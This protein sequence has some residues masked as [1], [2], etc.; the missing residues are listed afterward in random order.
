MSVSSVAKLE[1]AVADWDDWLCHEKRAAR[2]TLAS[3]RRDLNAFLNFVAQHRRSAPNLAD[4]CA[5]ET[6]DFR[7]WLAHRRGRGAAP[8]S[9]AR[10]VAVVRGFYRF[11]DRRGLGHNPAALALRAPKVRRSLPRPLSV[12]DA[13]DAATSAHEIDD[14]P[15]VAARDTALFTILYGCGLR[16]SEALALTCGEVGAS[17]DV[18]R[19]TGKGNKTRLVPVLPLVR[20]ALDTYMRQRPGS[21]AAGDPVFV[22]VRGGPLQAA[23]AQ[24]QMRKLRALLDMDETATPHA[25]R[26]SFATHLLER[27]ADLRTI[28]ELLGHASLST[29]QRYTDVASAHLVAVHDR[30]HPRARGHANGGNKVR[31]SSKTA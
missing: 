8:T 6:I 1:A 20:A 14:R 9:T 17:S 7:A 18:W 25:L 16:I 10:A 27:G 5:L 26:H 4:L 21:V 13:R 28:Q 24:R 11:L 19:I 22:G 15:W 29:T 3:Y 30:A 2:H 23:V 12:T 31:N